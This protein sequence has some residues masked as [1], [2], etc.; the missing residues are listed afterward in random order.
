MGI[1][2]CKRPSQKAALSQLQRGRGRVQEN[3]FDGLEKESQRGGEVGQTGRRDQQQQ[4]QKEK[5]RKSLPAGTP[6]R[7]FL[8]FRWI[9]PGRVD[10]L[11][12]FYC[13]R[14]CS[15]QF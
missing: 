1:M 7:T 9:E 2:R 4:Q 13:S 6:G 10:M 12:H 8:L 3:H 11:K 14:S 15:E 5:K